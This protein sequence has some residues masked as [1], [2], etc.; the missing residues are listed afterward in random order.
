MG[1]AEFTLLVPTKNGTQMI[2][3]TSNNAIRGSFVLVDLPC[4]LGKQ[5]GYHS[6]SPKGLSQDSSA[7]LL[8]Q[9]KHVCTVAHIND[10]IE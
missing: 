7:F 3:P 1:L 6:F 4:G 8:M 5:N 10:I 9:C 2:W